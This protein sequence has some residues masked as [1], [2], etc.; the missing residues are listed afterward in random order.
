MILLDDDPV[1]APAPP[2]LFISGACHDGDETVVLISPDGPDFWHIFTAAPE[3]DD[4]SPDPMDRWSRRVITPWAATLGGRP[5]L[6]SDGPPFAPFS[7]WALASGRF[8]SSPVGMIV[9]DTMG[10]W[11]SFRG[12]VILPG[13]RTLA[14]TDTANPCTDCPRPCLTACPA[15]AFRWGYDVALCHDWLD[16]VQ[17]DDCKSSGCGVRRACPIS[18]GCGRLPQQSAWHMRAF[19]P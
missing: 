18:A 7:R 9:H 12:A 2:G 19:H 13:R 14:P 15:G 6:P 16:G 1:A 3:F 10:L 5:I 8:W 17:A 11:A 4:G